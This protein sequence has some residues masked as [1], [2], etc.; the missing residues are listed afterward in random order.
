MFR[1][2]KSKGWKA[3][4]SRTCRD[5]SI[6]VEPLEGR[7]L[8]TGL[9]P[10]GYPIATSPSPSPVMA[11]APVKTS[12]PTPTSAPV[13]V[14]S[15]H[16]QPPKPSGIVTKAPRFYQFY[17]GPKLQELNAVKA[18]GE[19][20][21]NGNFTFTGTNQ[22]RITK[23]PAVYVWGIDRSGNL[24]AGSFK[25][26]PNVKFDAVVVVTLNHS[27]KPT[28]MVVD[29]ANGKTTDLPAGSASIKGATVSVTVPGSLLPSTG[30]APSQYRFNYWPEDGG[31]PVS[32]SVASF[33]PETN[34]VQVG[35]D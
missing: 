10:N 29:I 16:A 19:L 22:G 9:Y 14:A 30:L 27:L 7:P 1:R 12:T 18:S 24:A 13:P 11:P 26:R 28:A 25:G 20:S 3:T 15:H 5:V 23:A 31:P 8:L 6:A 17:K 4:G 21:S 34:T 35:S 32:S 33:A 2:W